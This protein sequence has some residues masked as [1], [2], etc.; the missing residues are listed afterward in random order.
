MIRT[1]TALTRIKKENNPP[2][3]M[4]QL[5]FYFIKGS[6]VF[7]KSNS[8]SPEPKSQREI[9]KTIIENSKDYS[10]IAKILSD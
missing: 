10:G 7:P 8:T 2:K 6:V 4:T 9:L 1:A 3:R 5:F